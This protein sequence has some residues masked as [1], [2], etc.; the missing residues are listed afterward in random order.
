MARFITEDGTYRTFSRNKDVLFLSDFDEYPEADGYLVC[1][2][3]DRVRTCITDNNGQQ[4]FDKPKSAICTVSNYERHIR[5]HCKDC[6]YSLFEEGLEKYWDRYEESKASNEIRYGVNKD[7]LIERNGGLWMEKHGRFARVE[8]GI[9]GILYAYDPNVPFGG[10]PKLFGSAMRNMYGDLIIT[11]HFITRS[12]RYCGHM[13]VEY[14]DKPGTYLV[15]L[16]YGK[17]YHVRCDDIP[18]PVVRVKRAPN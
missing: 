7:R 5:I 9:N 2:V 11:K 3:G 4:W 6:S 14:G 16:C 8:E 15:L 17:Y 13:L 1:V 12:A 18:F 10:E